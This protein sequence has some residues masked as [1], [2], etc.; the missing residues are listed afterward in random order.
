MSRELRAERERGRPG[1]VDRLS[2]AAE[3]LSRAAN[4]WTVTAARMGEA[5]Q[6]LAEHQVRIAH[7]EAELLRRVIMQFLDA[8]GLEVGRPMRRRAANW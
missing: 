6:A 3:K 1:S 2:G 8:L 7:E 5:E 4:C